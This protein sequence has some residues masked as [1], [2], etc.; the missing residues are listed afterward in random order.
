MS[1]SFVKLSIFPVE[2]RMCREKTE[3]RILRV[4]TSS[5]YA[6]IST[7]RYENVAKLKQQ[8]WAHTI[9]TKHAN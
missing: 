6:P 4:P 8:D 7:F 2:A 5:P 3:Q 1:M 9:V